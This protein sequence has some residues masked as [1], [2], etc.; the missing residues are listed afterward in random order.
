MF[1]L[2]LRMRGVRDKGQEQQDEGRDPSKSEQGASLIQAD[3]I[4]A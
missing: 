2:R 4:S 3:V 1:G